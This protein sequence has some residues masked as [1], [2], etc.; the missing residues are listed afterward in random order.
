MNSSSLTTIPS[1][2][3]PRDAPDRKKGIREKQM[4]G[5]IGLL[6]NGNLLVAVR[7]DSLLVRL[8]PERGEIA[9]LEPHVAEFQIKVPVRRHC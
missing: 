8:G 5:G 3:V 1:P 7:K 6:R 4:F 9:L 2:L